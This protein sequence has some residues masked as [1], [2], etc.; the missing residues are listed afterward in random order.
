MP[1]PFKLADPLG[2]HVGLVR[3]VRSLVSGCRY[4]VNA[5]RVRELEI[6]YIYV[7]FQVFLVIAID[8]KNGQAMLIKI[9]AHI[10]KRNR[11]ALRQVEE[12][13]RLHSG[14]FGFGEYSRLPRK[15]PV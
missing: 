5:N 1:T 11:S 15:L 14:T 7:G 8:H 9:S 12:L 6:R 3:A 4:R 10:Q 13:R 2:N